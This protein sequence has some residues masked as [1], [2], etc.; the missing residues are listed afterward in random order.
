MPVAAV[1]FVKRIGP[2]ADAFVTGDADRDCAW[3]LHEGARVHCE[4]S[5]PSP[6]AGATPSTLA[7]PCELA[8]D[9]P[10]RAASPGALPIACGSTLIATAYDLSAGE[11]ALMLPDGRFAGSAHATRYLAIYAGDGALL[12]DETLEK[13]RTTPS[14]VA[15]VIAATHPTVWNLRHPLVFA[16]EPQ[17]ERGKD[18]WTF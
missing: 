18:E 10:E 1:G 14:E 7:G 6:A 2:G 12:G 11:W 8:V 5:K 16:M 9:S 13:L 15:R 17:S 3:S 4:P